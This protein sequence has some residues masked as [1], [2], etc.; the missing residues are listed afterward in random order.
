[1]EEGLQSS[2][3]GRLKQ[4]AEGF[5]ARKVKTAEGEQKW[6]SGATTKYGGSGHL[7]SPDAG[8]W[9][10]HACSGAAR[11]LC[12]FSRAL[13][14]RGI[15]LRRSGRHAGSS[16]PARPLQSLSW[17]FRQV[18]SVSGPPLRHT[19]S[20]ASLLGV[21][22]RKRSTRPVAACDQESP[23]AARGARRGGQ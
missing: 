14:L 13:G 5:I 16:A 7:R 11:Y 23:A 1:M 20:V 8:Q 21:R 22:R 4:P 6:L 3:L 18:V 19:C 9:T 2:T 17:P 15:L 10:A 12:L